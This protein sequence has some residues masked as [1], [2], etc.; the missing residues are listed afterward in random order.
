MNYNVIN[1]FDLLE[2][3]IFFIQKVCVKEPPEEHIQT[4]EQ[5]RDIFNNVLYINYLFHA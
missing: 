5:T 4:T 3:Y 2:L 1:W